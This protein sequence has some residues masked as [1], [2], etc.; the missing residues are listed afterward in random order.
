MGAAS[1]ND[2]DIV[3]GINV[4]PLVDVCLARLFMV[5]AP[6][7]RSDHHGPTAN[8][9]KDDKKRQIDDH[10]ARTGVSDQKEFKDIGLEEELRSG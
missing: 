2:D 1:T 8:A 4:T 5:T 3:S 6:R 7:C 9:K 10:S